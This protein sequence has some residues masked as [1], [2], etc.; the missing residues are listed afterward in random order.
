M[1]CGHSVCLTDEC[2]EII[3][4]KEAKRHSW[5]S[6]AL[7][8]VDHKQCGGVLIKEQW[9]LTAAHCKGTDMKVTL[10]AHSVS[11]KEKEKQRFTV[12]QAFPYEKFNNK[13][14]KNDIML[15]KLKVPVKTNQYI[16]TLALPAEGKDIKVKT[17]CRTA[18]WGITNM[19][20]KK[21]S[22]KLMEVDISVVSRKQ[23]QTYYKKTV[24]TNS[25]LCAW[26]KDG[27]KDTSQGDSGGPL[28][29]NGK[30]AAITS[31]GSKSGEAPG[32][33][34]LLTTKFIKWIHKVTGG[35]E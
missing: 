8:Q 30:Y 24:I 32:V 12:S 19:K 5:P 18:G 22:D 1:H 26:D 20:N 28:L 27:K 14:F 4:G 31:F 3:G 9:V 7:I 34:T 21:G 15:L 10:G 2:E 25:M 13:T 35:A 17:T 11:K 29:C 16:K 23:C 6:L 33:Y